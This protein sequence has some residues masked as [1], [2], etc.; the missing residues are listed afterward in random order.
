MVYSWFQYDGDISF[1]RLADLNYPEIES[2]NIIQCLNPVI[3]IIL[4]RLKLALSVKFFI[5]ALYVNN[6]NRLN[7]VL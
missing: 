3:L 4:T 6:P 1:N 7:L 2:Y 5:F